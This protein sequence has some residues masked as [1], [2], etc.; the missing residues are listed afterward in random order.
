MKNRSFK[1]TVMGLLKFEDYWS[2]LLATVILIFCIGT[3]FS[4]APGDL[5]NQISEKNMIMKAEAEK[6][7]FKTV[8]WYKSQQNKNGISAA[9]SVVKGIKGYLDRPRSWNKNPVEAFYLSKSEAEIRNAE[10][11]PAYEAAK[12]QTAKAEADAIS[13]ETAAAAVNYNNAQLNDDAKTKVDTWIAAR[14]AES[15][16]KGKATVKPYNLMP[17]LV[18]LG[19]FICAYFSSGMKSMGKST[20]DFMT[21][22]PI[23]FALAIVAYLLGAQVTFKAWGL[24][25]VFWGLVLGLMIS[26]TVGTPKFVLQAAQTEYYIKTGLIL[27]GSTVLVNKVLLIGMPGIFVTW[28]V[29]PIVL[30]LTFLFGEY[31]VK[32]ESKSLNMVMS[33]DMS[34]SGVSAAIAAAAACKA[35]KEEL[36]LSVGIS[37]MFTAVMMIVMPM[38]IKKIGMN[39]VLGGAW[40]G[41]TIDSTGAVVA[42]G[43][44]LGPAARDVA[45]TIK[46]IQNII[47]GVMALGVATFWSLKV[48]KDAGAAKKITLKGSLQE[49]WARFPKFIIGFIGASVLFSIIYSILGDD[50]AKVIIDNGMVKDIISPL[51]GWLFCLAFTSI[52]LSTNFVELGKQMKGGKPILLYTAGKII[53]LGVTLAVAYWAFHIAFPEITK[54]LMSL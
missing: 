3:F 34:V 23:V 8:A 46:M 38:F 41:G 14:T 30:V 32:M 53:N 31:V 9:G 22:F 6:A 17:G 27:L 36:T 20:K 12:I 44:Y 7:P 33:A 35:K 48:E 45:A 4:Q 28:L 18:V 47:I 42:A 49:I 26:N 54:S 15:K 1:E 29:T 43:E 24:E 5:E 37:I 50:M 52:G 10:A 40:I 51:Q 19:L 16:A 13:A 11:I 21:G 39:P 25:Y 2:I